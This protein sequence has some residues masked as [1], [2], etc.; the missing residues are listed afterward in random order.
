MF[1][2]ITKLD[3]SRQK[4]SIHFSKDLFCSQLVTEASGRCAVKNEQNKFFFY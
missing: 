2:G 3:L 1:N 4:E